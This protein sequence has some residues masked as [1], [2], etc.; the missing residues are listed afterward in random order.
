MTRDDEFVRAL[1]DSLE[2]R[3]LPAVSATEHPGYVEGWTDAMDVAIDELE[4]LLDPID[5]RQTIAD[6]R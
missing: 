6:P 5:K 1:L 4:C 3:R 2:R